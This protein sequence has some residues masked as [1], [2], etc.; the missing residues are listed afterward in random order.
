MCV[1][2][3]CVSDLRRNL[4]RVESA[5]KQTHGFSYDLSVL[6]DLSMELPILRQRDWLVLLP[7]Q[8]AIR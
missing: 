5:T 7:N 3:M 1:G 8:L 4:G 2:C 6:M